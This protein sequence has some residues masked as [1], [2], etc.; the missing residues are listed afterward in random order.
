M[1][2]HLAM[3]QGTGAPRRA[4]IAIIG[5]GSPY[6]AG[7]LHAF[8]SQA[9]HPRGLELISTP[10]S[11]FVRHVDARLTMERTT[12]RRAAF[13]HADSG[14]TS[15]R[16]GGLDE[17]IPLRTIA[18]I[19]E[20]A[21]R[22]FRLN[23][24]NPSNPVTKA[25]TH[26]SSSNILGLCDGPVH[27][28]ARLAVGQRFLQYTVGL[29]H[30]TWTTAL[31]LEGRDMLPQIVE[32]VASS[33][34]LRARTY[35]FVLQATLTAR[36]G[37]IPSDYLPDSFPEQVQQY[38]YRKPTT[39]AEDS[40]AMLPEM[41]AYSREEAYKEVPQL[42]LVRGGS[43][44]G[45]FAL[46]ILRSILNNTGEE[47]ILNVPNRGTLDVLPADR[48]S[49]APCSVDARGASSL[50]QGDGG[51]AIK[52][53]GL[54]CLPGEFEGGRRLD[55]M[56]ALAANLS[57]MS[58]SKAEAVDDHLAAAHAPSLPTR[59]LKNEAGGRF[60]LRF[61]HGIMQREATL[62]YHCS[63]QT[64]PGHGHARGSKL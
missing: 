62:T 31:C 29:N 1:A 60:Q 54:I 7:L 10:G 39:R 14:L 41:P 36:Y 37:A 9:H 23:A 35:P 38:A 8:A 26:A 43:G 32:R 21:L 27:E 24:T 15:V 17:K 56:K 13:S 58:Y 25:V 6:G 5:G 3:P 11:T 46:D 55:A 48:V 2:E 16:T 19:V 47:W 34:P 44:V 18:M 22:A 12:L 42:R 57:V 64:R 50:M 51:L 61:L 4:K 33:L 53:R 63:V 20:I 28:V 59:L 40:M 45:D 49:K 52:Q 30:G